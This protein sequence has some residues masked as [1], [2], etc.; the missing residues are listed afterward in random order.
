MVSDWGW[1]LA[2]GWW[3]Y[4]ILAA[5]ATFMNILYFDGLSFCFCFSFLWKLISVKRRWDLSPRIGM[6]TVTKA[7]TRQMSW[8]TRTYVNLCISAGP[9]HSHVTVAACCEPRY[10]Q[11]LKPTINHTYV[12]G[13]TV[14]QL[15]MC[16]PL[17]RNV[18]CNPEEVVASVFYTHY[19]A[20]TNWWLLI[21]V[22]II[23]FV[24]Y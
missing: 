23:L 17:C 8:G 5:R 24:K 13:V 14:W 4:A 9:A 12:G 20:C 2:V 7:G 11:H 18:K 3:L 16:I 1:L 6:T 10:Y 22:C 15:V 19:D 21:H